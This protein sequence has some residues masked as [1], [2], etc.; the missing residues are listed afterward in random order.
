MMSYVLNYGNE[1]GILGWLKL[2]SNNIM[3]ETIMRCDIGMIVLV[4]LKL[5]EE[6]L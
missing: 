4:K 3:V 2:L 1:I 5:S 6:I